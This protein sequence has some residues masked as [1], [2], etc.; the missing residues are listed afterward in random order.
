MIRYFA[1]AAVVAALVAMAAIGSKALGEPLGNVLPT[2]GVYDPRPIYPVTR[3]LEKLTGQP[4]VTVV[5]MNRPPEADNLTLPYQPVALPP[6]PRKHV[7][8]RELGGRLDAHTERFKAWAENGD[9]VEVHGVCHS[10]CTLVMSS[11]RRDDICFAAGGYLS[12]HKASNA[13]GSPSLYYT[14]WMI[15]AYPADIQRW[16]KARGGAEQMPHTGRWTVTAPELWQMG[17]KRCD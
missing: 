1:I 11:I 2:P 14:Q 17:Y 5:P 4:G 8:M 13:D 6:A 10:A 15:G 3:S 9:R 16:I 7:I 12:F